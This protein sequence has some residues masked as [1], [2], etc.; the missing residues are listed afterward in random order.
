M[1]I[2]PTRLPGVSLI[3]P[4][5]HADDRGFFQEIWN[6]RS[7]ADHGI[8]ADFMQDNHSR[9]HRGVLRGLH[10]QLVQPQGK[11]VR[12]TQGAVFDVAVDIRPDSPSFGR[13]TGH[14]L[15]AQNRLMMW[16]PPGFAHGFL[17]LEDDTDVLYKCTAI[18]APAN[19]RSIL[20]NDPDIAIQWPLDGQSPRL[21]A[22]DAAAPMLADGAR[23]MA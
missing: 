8:I 15:S 5:R 7:F 13:W 10:H 2:T 9:S 20:W 19:E 23:V 14:V 12:V 21:S 1:N 17:S 18:Y 11:L 22:K 4:T 16:V 6:S 3:E